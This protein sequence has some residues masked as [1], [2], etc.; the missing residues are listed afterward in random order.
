LVKVCNKQDKQDDVSI[1][2]KR[3][4]KPM[5]SP[6]IGLAQA[7]SPSELLYAE[8]HSYCNT[9]TINSCPTWL[10]EQNLVYH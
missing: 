2:S 8:L 6:T 10:G 7:P 1:M 4:A 5:T 9:L 3:A